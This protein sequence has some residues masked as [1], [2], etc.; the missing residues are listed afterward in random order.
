MNQPVALHT[1][2]N[3]AEA[4]DVLEHLERAGI[5]ADVF[6]EASAF[7]ALPQITVLVERRD[8]KRAQTQLRVFQAG[9]LSEE[10]IA[11]EASA[12]AVL[13]DDLPERK[14]R[15]EILENPAAVGVFW[16]YQHV[17][18]IGILSLL[19]PLG[20]L[21][22]PFL[23]I[24]TGDFIMEPFIPGILLRALATALVLGL[25]RIVWLPGKLN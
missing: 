20:Y 10:P 11:D 13:A 5:E 7:G 16:R 3:P 1:T 9:S 4:D 22:Y 17:I 8:L 25:V 14:E 12:D 19:T 6:D 15:V 18:A 21:T 2:W 24:L 23:T